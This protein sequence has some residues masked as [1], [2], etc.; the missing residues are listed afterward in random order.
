MSVGYASD[1]RAVSISGASMKQLDPVPLPGFDAKAQAEDPHLPE[2]GD[3][4][5]TCLAEALDILVDR[6]TRHG[7]VEVSHLLEVAALAARDAA[8]APAGHRCQPERQR[9]GARSSLA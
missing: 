1:Q 3:D 7:L 5:P 6:A 9:D 4:F 2:D 8:A